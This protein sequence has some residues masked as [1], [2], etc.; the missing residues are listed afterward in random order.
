M[1]VLPLSLLPTALLLTAAAPDA[2]ITPGK[3]TTIVTIDD[4]KLADGPPAVAAMMRGRPITTTYCVTPE[5]ARQ[6]I[7]G[8]LKPETG[9]AFTQFAVV[10]NRISTRMECR[11][12]T[13]TMTS[14][15]SG[16]YTPTAFAMTSAMTGTGR[17]TMNMKSHAVGKRVGGC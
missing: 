7:R 14:I 10:G 15:S 8:A 17:M 13:G 5:Q 2:V 1:K 9:C 4:V 11:R 3:W 6:G 12:P 16:T